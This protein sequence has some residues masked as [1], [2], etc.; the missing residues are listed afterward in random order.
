MKRVHLRKGHSDIILG[1][2]KGK[3]MRNLQPPET[4]FAKKVF[5]FSLISINEA[6]LKKRF[7][8]NEA[9]SYYLI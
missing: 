6:N 2:L 9:F 8:I 3:N 1:H 4:E 5:I 7:E